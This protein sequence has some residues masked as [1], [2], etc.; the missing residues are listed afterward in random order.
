MVHSPSPG[1]GHATSPIRNA[2][3]LVAFIMAARGR[4]TSHRAGWPGA[5]ALDGLRPL[6][7]EG[8]DGEEGR[9]GERRAGGAHTR[10][11]T[12]GSWGQ[13]WASALPKAES[14][15][16]GTSRP[17]HVIFNRRGLSDLGS[18]GLCEA[19][20]ARQLASLLQQ[21]AVTACIV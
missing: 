21:A 3:T 13:C 15:R 8:G 2:C 20:Q 11:Y 12:S 6:G 14:S 1:T 7:W 16:D 9:E 10:C 18:N 4:D 17:T 5:W 19:R